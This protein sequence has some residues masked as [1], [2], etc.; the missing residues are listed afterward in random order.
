M[1][2]PGI[3]SV[4]LAIAVL[5][6]ISAGFGIARGLV[7]EL[8]SLVIWAAALLLGILFAVPVADWTGLDL[9]SGRLQVAVGFAIVFVLV[10]VAGAI[11]QRIIGGLIE[12]TGL[13]GTDRTLGLLFGALRGVVL[14]V[15]VLIALRPFAEESDWW[16][17]SRLV[18]ALLT[19]EDDILAAG[20]YLFDASGISDADIQLPQG[21]L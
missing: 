20:R 14:V 11:A 7:K 10:L 1:T 5:V 2:D 18:P 16:S 19:L 8:V 9:G 6:L 13:S 3:A 4:D 21:E 15:V 17:E 12:S